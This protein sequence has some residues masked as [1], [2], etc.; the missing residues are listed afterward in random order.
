[1]IIGSGSETSKRHIPLFNMIQ[2][3]NYVGGRPWGFHS[4]YSVLLDIFTYFKNLSLQVSARKG[5]FFFFTSFWVSAGGNLK[6]S[7]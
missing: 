1:M 6:I 2:I 5:G 7:K 3:T 4:L